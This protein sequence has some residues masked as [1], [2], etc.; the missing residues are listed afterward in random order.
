MKK[1]IYNYEYGKEA[2][3]AK[4]RPLKVM[5][6]EIIPRMTALITQRTSVAGPMLRGHFLDLVQEYS[7]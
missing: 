5:A 2:F 4:F 3:L 1:I 7:D 6:F